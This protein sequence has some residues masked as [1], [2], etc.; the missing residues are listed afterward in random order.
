MASF[1]SET[2]G[3][4]YTTLQVSTVKRVHMKLPDHAACTGDDS[5]LR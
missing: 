4:D 1:D 5:C 3:V 2:P